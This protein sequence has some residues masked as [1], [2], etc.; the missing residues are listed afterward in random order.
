[1]APASRHPRAVSAPIV[2]LADPRPEPVLPPGSSRRK[3]LVLG[4]DGLRPDRLMDADAPR[5]KDLAAGGLFGVSSLYCSPAG[6]TGSGA[7]WATV[8]SGVWPDRNSV[9]DGNLTSRRARRFPDFL[10]RAKQHRESFSTVSVSAWT[11]IGH[12]EWYGGPLVSEAV[13][14]RINFD[15]DS[16][17]PDEVDAAVADVAVRLLTEQDP[18]LMFVHLGGIDLA[19]HAG[20]AALPRYLKTISLV[21]AQVG[22]ILDALS[23]RPARAEEEWL[24]LATNDHGHQDH[25]T[26]HN[27][28]S[29]AE[30]GWFLIA[31]G[32][33]ITAGSPRPD[34]RA[35]D[36][37]PTVLH[38]LGVP[39]DPA[40]GLDGRPAQTPAEDPFDSMLPEL[41]P[42]PDPLL[43]PGGTSGGLTAAA[44]DGW[45]IE[46]ECDA[47]GQAEWAGWRLTTD[48][49]WTAQERGRGRE[50]FTRARGVFAVAD[51]ALWRGAGDG[52]VE[53]G[54]PFDST[55]VSQGYPVAGY[56]AVT[57]DFAAHY[58]RHAD[59]RATV[60]VSFDEG[61]EQELL[62]Y[63]PDARDANHGT[64]VVARQESLHLPVPDGAR[65]LRLRWKLH[66]EGSGWFAVDGVR[67][68]PGLRPR[69]ELT[70]DTA[71]PEPGGEILITGRLHGGHPH[72]VEWTL[73][74]DLD[75]P[76]EPAGPGSWRVRVPADASREPSWLSAAA[77]WD[78]G[79]AVA[80]LVLA[81]PHPNLDAAR[82][83]TATSADSEPGAAG[84]AADGEHRSWSREALAAAGYTVRRNSEGH[85]AVLCGGQ[86]IRLTGRGGTLRLL[87]ASAFYPGGGQGAVLFRDGSRQPFDLYIPAWDTD[88]ADSPH[89][90]AVDTPRRNG[91]GGDAEETPARIYRIDIP[92]HP[93][94]EPIGILLPDCSDRAVSYAPSPYLFSCAVV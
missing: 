31:N 69:I 42:A 59:G 53:P 20:G 39:I 72:R 86:A 71:L 45:S 3:V 50:T 51:P 78:G 94:A 17:A 76:I 10:T 9:R 88:P 6:V 80:D 66:T 79:A 67:V 24:V 52:A 62:R 64:D 90:V 82:N 33:G 14:A 21:D 61:P 46:S 36:V 5:L 91:P 85:D 43:I 74:A 7:G 84:G 70:A 15:C 81:V 65:M 28:P 2:R 22:R 32:P 19:G 58:R 16:D 73:S 13:D 41:V 83:W 37:A 89:P 26:C 27:G 35:A 12:R 25:G 8:L 55:L 63:G 23:S 49:Y 34:L 93:D 47:K 54:R 38:H 18:D 75:W 29:A 11:A 57:V 92:L 68:L 48:A 60:S 44:P 77:R 4:L 56:S 87:A 1:M 30:R 40:W